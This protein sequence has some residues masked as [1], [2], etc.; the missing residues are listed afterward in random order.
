MY[1]TGILVGVAIVFYFYGI[2]LRLWGAQDGG[3]TGLNKLR[4]QLLWGLLALFVILSIW[5]ILSLLG[6][7]LFG[8]NNFNSL[9]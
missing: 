8:T 5:G 3:A 4:G 7:L 2:V 6:N 1:G 9:F